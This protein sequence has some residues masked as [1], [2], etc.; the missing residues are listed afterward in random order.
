MLADLGP[1]L[2]ESELPKAEDRRRQ[3]MELVRDAGRLVA[4][5]GFRIGVVDSPGSWLTARHGRSI[6]L[7]AW[8]GNVLKSH[9]VSELMAGVPEIYY[10]DCATG[11]CT[12]CN[13]FR[14][15]HYD[16]SKADL[17]WWTG[18]Y[19]GYAGRQRAVVGGAGS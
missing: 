5:D 19:T 12:F 2:A 10:D 15:A 13:V 4:D 18:P 1:D 8:G 7:M 3:I 14:D 6:N 17:Y 9:E 11:N 16:F